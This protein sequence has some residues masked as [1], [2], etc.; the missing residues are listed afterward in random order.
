[1]GV[2]ASQIRK[3]Q[4]NVDAYVDKTTRTNG[5]RFNPRALSLHPGRQSCLEHLKDELLRFIYGQREEGITVSV[6]TVVKFVQPRDAAFRGKS[7]EAQHQSVRR[8]VAANGLVHRVHTHQSQRSFNLVKAEALK[9]IE[10]ARLLVNRDQRFVINMDQTPIFFSTLPRTTLEPIGSRTVNVRT[11]TGSTLRVTIA[12][13]V[14]ANG[15]MLPPLIVFKGKPKGR[16]SREFPS[17]PARAVYTVQTHA[18][19]D[20][21]IMN[22]RIDQILKQKLLEWNHF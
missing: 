16:I 14:T 19:M 4:Q 18:W 2:D 9:W 13:T 15:D 3:W 22:I 20:E 17:Y 8:F 21:S 6:K 5:T 12:V 7:E 1:L 11:S 10:E